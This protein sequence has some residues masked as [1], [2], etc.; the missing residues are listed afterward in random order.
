MKKRFFI[1]AVRAFLLGA[2]LGSAVVIL[3]LLDERFNFLGLSSMLPQND[4]L[5]A[6]IDLLTGIPSEVQALKKR[7]YAEFDPGHMEYYFHQ[8]ETE[9]KK[10]YRQMLEGIRERRP[11]FYL[12]ISESEAVSR[13]AHALY[14]DHPELYFVH[15]REKSFTTTYPGRSYCEFSPGYTYTYTEMQEIGKRMEGAFQEVCAMLPDNPSDYD[16]AEAVYV[17]LIDHTDYQENEHDQNI[18][19]VFWKKEAVCAGYARAAMYLL[20]RLNLPCIFVEGDSLESESG[21]LHAWNIIAIDGEYYYMDTTNG[22][23][24]DFLM[25]EASQLLEHKTTVMDYLCPFPD[26]Y[27]KMYRCSEEFQ[28]PPC[29]AREMNFYVKNGSFISPYEWEAVLKLC[30]LRIDNNA[31]VVRFRVGSEEDFQAARS[32]WIDGESSR[33]ISQ[34]YMKQ[35]RMEYVE[36]YCGTLDTFKT[37]YYIF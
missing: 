22:D 36:Y 34:Y 1:R 3:F 6:V 15:N 12:T 30:R 25:G 16:L 29:T 23:Q 2:I 21:E 8:L 26:E 14:M 35:N 13:I 19:G 37:F 5:E 31:A 7:E 28:L 10:V 17:Y 4:T 32:E 9:E 33:L 24:P 11:S 27:E 20:E 18:A